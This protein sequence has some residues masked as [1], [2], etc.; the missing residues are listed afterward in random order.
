[1]LPISPS[2]VRNVRPMPPRYLNFDEQVVPYEQ[3]GF[4]LVDL[5]VDRIV[6]R[7]FKWDVNSGPLAAI[8]SLEPYHVV[9]LG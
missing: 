1:M 4:T 6:A 2:V 7:L 9:E 5:E 3:H 8:D